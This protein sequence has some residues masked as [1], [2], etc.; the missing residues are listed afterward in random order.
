MLV[1]QW[2]GKKTT[3]KTLLGNNGWGETRT[4][5]TLFPRWAIAQISACPL[6]YRNRSCDNCAF[7]WHRSRIQTG[8][9]GMANGRLPGKKTAVIPGQ[10][11]TTTEWQWKPAVV[12]EGGSNQSPAQNEKGK[13]MTWKRKRH[14]KIARHPGKKILRKLYFFQITKPSRCPYFLRSIR[15]I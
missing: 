14:A 12:G 9:A 6:L 10:N 3:L 7:F 13:Q 11:S 8:G 5:V 2:N 1:R 15:A 4:F